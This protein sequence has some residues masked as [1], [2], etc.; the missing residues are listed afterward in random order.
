MQFVPQPIRIVPLMFLLGVAPLFVL[1]YWMW[2]VRLRK[3]L[4]GMTIGSR[5]AVNEPA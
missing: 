5:P 1:L 4:G 3:R 2:R